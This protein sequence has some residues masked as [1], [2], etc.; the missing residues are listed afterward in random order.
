MFRPT[1]RA[2]RACPWRSSTLTGCAPQRFGT[3]GGADPQPADETTADEIGS[4]GKVLTGMLLSD[5]GL[6]PDTPVS[7]LLPDVEFND[8]GTASATLA[9]LASHRSGLP[10]LCI[11]PPSLARSVLHRFIGVDPYAGDGRAAVLA[12][13]PQYP[14]AASARS[15][16]PTW[17]WHCSARPWPS[18]RGS[19]TAHCSLSGSSSRSA[20]RKPRWPAPKPNYR[21]PG[22]TRS[23]PTGWRS[24]PGWRAAGTRRQ[25]DRPGVDA[26]D[27]RR[28]VPIALGLAL[29]IRLAMI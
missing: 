8:A 25:I 22:P 20:C 17:G 15:A 19:P 12:A 10:R 1:R 26:G 27:R 18:G 5:S 29:A 11:T 13:P 4:V 14:R 3:T 28:A 9:E 23:G 24:N 7:E 2:G 16:I 21:Y 6:D